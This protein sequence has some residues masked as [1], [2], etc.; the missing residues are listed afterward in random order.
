LVVKLTRSLMLVPIVL[1]LVLLKTRREARLASAGSTGTE[2]VKPRLPWRKLVPLFLVGFIAAAGLRSAGLVPNSW[3]SGLSLT[4]TILI[5][6]A[7]VAIGLSLRPA[8]LRKAGL[9]PLLL[10]A[11]LWIC[12]A[13]SSLLLQLLTGTL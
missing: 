12:V 1:T 9:R 13:A 5:T 7:L 10:G 4:G 2:S 11:I 3:Q 8:E 6:S